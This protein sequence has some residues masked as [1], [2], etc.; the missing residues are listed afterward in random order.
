MTMGADVLL[1]VRPE[2]VS[3]RSGT[4]AHESSPNDNIVIARV[5][6]ISFLGNTIRYAVDAG[7]DCVITV[8]APN[9]RTRPKM[10]VGDAATVSWPL[11]D[12]LLLA[13]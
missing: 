7:R 4:E 13:P 6:S 10:S 12:S 1:F 8:D 3:I 5:R 9:V 11:A 2:K